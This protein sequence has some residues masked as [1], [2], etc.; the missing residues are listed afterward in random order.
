VRRLEVHNIHRIRWTL[1]LGL[2]V[3]LVFVVVFAASVTPMV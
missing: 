1:I 2:F 3:M